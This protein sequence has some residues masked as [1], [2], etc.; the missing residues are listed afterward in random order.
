MN[1]M[2]DFVSSYSGDK[3]VPQGLRIASTGRS[4]FCAAT[5]YFRCATA[6]PSSNG[7]VG[8]RGHL[9]DHQVLL[10]GAERVVMAGHGFVGFGWVW[11]GCAGRVVGTTLA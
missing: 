5:H 8:S 11:F 6:S 7:F 1:G 2:C 3:R 9:L 10:L 4:N